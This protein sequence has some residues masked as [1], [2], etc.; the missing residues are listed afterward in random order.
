MEFRFLHLAERVQHLLF[1]KHFNF[2]FRRICFALYTILFYV[3]LEKCKNK[4]RPPDGERFFA[5]FARLEHAPN[6][7][8]VYRRGS[9]SATN[10]RAK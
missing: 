8:R 5:V 1:G 10:L 9:A 2:L 3:V 4:K 6:A 7:R